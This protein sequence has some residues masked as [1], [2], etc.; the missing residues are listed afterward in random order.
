[1]SPGIQWFHFTYLGKWW[2]ASGRK[3]PTEELTAWAEKVFE[4]E[5]VLCFDVHVDEKGEIDPLQVEQL[6][7]VARILEKIKANKN[8]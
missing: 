7:A 3:T 5:G 4:K 6:K 8:K 1:L 2:G